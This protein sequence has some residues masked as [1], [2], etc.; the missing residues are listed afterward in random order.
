MLIYLAWYGLIR[1]LLESIRTSPLYI[2]G[3]R[4]LASQVLMG[5][6]CLIAVIALIVQ[7]RKP[8]DPEELWVNRVR[9]AKEAEETTEESEKT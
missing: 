1:V 8:H 7:G 4:L 5:A 9:A 6:V 3:T 2:P